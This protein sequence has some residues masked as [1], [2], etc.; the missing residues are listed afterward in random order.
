MPSDAMSYRDYLVWTAAHTAAALTEAIRIAMDMH[1]GY[2]IRHLEAK[3]D[4]VPELARYGSPN[5]E[6]VLPRP[7][8]I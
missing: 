4:V 6:R 7:E 2:A 8:N 1:E 3:L 5:P